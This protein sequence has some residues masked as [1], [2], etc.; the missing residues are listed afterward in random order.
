[1]EQSEQKKR[2][3]S[4]ET[5]YQLIRAEIL[6]YLN[7]YQAVRNRMYVVTLSCLGLSLGNNI[8]NPYLYLLPLIVI[9][10]SFLA[11]AN[12]WKCVVIDSAYLRVFHEDRGSGFHW[13]TRHDR[14]FQ[15][16]PWLE[17][18]I[19]IQHLPYLVCSLV[20][21]LMF[22]QKAKAGTAV[23]KNAGWAGVLAAGVCIA[24]F[25]MNWK[26]D[27]ER[28]TRGWQK[29]AEREEEEESA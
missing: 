28:I 23:Y 3:T 10:P 1:M 16:E 13:E 19:N 17:D 25:A 24:T 12:F 22:W 9:L 15:Q 8:G 6:Q 2:Q 27:K 4:K 11:A 29:L 14:L 26:I 5:E 21:L 18:K 7:N 20:S